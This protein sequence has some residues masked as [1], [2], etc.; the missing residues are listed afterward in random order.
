MSG[1]CFILREVEVKRTDLKAGD[2]FRLSG[3]DGFENEGEY[4]VAT[5]DVDP[6]EG[7][8]ARIDAIGIKMNTDSPLRWGLNGVLLKRLR[9]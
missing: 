4:F 3:V 5:M 2:V 6:L 8:N 1:S 9:N 7:E